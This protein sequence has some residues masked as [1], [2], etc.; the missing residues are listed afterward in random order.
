MCRLLYTG[1]LIPK[2]QA[3][4]EKAMHQ[5]IDHHGHTAGETTVRE[6]A[7]KLWAS[8]QRGR[9]LGFSTLSTRFRP[10]SG[11]QSVILSLEPTLKNL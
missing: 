5:W 7:R 2:T 8:P 9:K 1:E 6:R 11:W 4:I 3:D 10:T